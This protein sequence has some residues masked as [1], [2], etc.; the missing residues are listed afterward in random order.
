M[1]FTINSTTYCTR[2]CCNHFVVFLRPKDMSYWN[3]KIVSLLW[4]I[5]EVY[6]HIVCFTGNVHAYTHARTA[7]RDI[8]IGKHI[9]SS[10]DIRINHPDDDEDMRPFAFLIHVSRS[11]CPHCPTKQTHRIIRTS[12]TL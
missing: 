4:S 3:Y 9:L 1:R 11:S 12:F 6:T 10:T 5:S 2:L 8:Q 7:S